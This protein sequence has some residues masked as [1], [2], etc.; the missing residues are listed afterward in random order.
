VIPDLRADMD[1]NYA[2]PPSK[3][4]LI[5]FKNRK[6]RGFTD[7]LDA[8]AQAAFM[9]IQ[10]DRY[11]HLVFSWQYGS[12]LGALIGKDPDYVLSEAKR[13]ISEALSTDTRITGVRDFSFSGGVISFTIDTVFGSKNI[14]KELDAL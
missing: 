11:R 13:M 2:E 1:L 9:A 7:E 3:T 12:E 10:C 4:W 14:K 8:V 5:D 6:V